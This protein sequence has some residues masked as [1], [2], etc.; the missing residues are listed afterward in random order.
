MLRIIR[1]IVIL[2]IILAG[3]AIHLRNDQ[4]VSLDYYLGQLELPFSLFLILGVCSGIVLGML[5]GLPLLIRIKRDRD[6]LASRIR[7]NEKELD[8]LRV[9]PVKNTF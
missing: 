4:P 1:F 7:M 3:L 6:K 5:A 9:I 8:N 2:V